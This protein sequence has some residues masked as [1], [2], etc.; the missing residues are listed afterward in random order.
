MQVMIVRDFQKL[1]MFK[2]YKVVLI[3]Y[4]TRNAMSVSVESSYF[5]EVPTNEFISNNS[6]SNNVTCVNY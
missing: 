1:W 2:R 3:L 5:V 6:L 4:R